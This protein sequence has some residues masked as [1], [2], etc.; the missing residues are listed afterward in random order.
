M[1]QYRY[2]SCSEN[3]QLSELT[4]K[5]IYQIIYCLVS[6]FSLQK[7]DWFWCR[8]PTARIAPCLPSEW[9]PHRRRIARPAEPAPTLQSSSSIPPRRI[10]PSI[11]R[12]RS[13]L[14][15]RLRRPLAGGDRSECAICLN[16]KR[17]HWRYE[18]TFGPPSFN[19]VLRKG[20]L[21]RG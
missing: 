12:S 4:S 17:L 2:W 20:Q 8:A 9:P 15:A 1:V 14:P 21:I 3:S 19:L 5:E 16:F 13:S 18:R 7:R 11:H 6:L 10:P